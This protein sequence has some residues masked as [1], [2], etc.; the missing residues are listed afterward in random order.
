MTKVPENVRLARQQQGLRVR[1]E[2]DKWAV[3]QFLLKYLR[4]QSIILAE[5]RK[6]LRTQPSP[7]LK[8]QIAFHK[9]QVS[10]IE[11]LLSVNAQRTVN[12]AS[13]DD[14]TSSERKSG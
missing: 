5:E 7:A 3:E 6:V 10:T 8:G 11:W 2:A 12:G 9:N 14:T 1:L 13:Q 4:S